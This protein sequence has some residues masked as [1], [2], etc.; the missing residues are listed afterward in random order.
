MQTITSQ[1]S[2][3][4][5]FALFTLVIAFIFLPL[6]LKGE[7]ICPFNYNMELGVSAD[8]N[9]SSYITNHKFGDYSHFFIPETSQN[10]Q[11]NS[12]S[13]ISVWSPWGE[14][15]RPTFTCQGVFGKAYLLTNMLSYFTSNP[16]V[17]QTYYAILMIF[18]SGAFFFLFLREKGLHPVS[19]STMAI[20]F[21]TSIFLFYWISFNIYLSTYCWTA[22]LL[23]LVTRYTKRLSFWTWFGVA[24]ATYSLLMTG[25]QQAIIMAAYLLVLYS[26]FH[27]WRLPIAC[28]G[29]LFRIAMLGL[30]AVAGFIAALPLY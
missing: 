22:A 5:T 12:R 15:G 24:F 9:E 29:K 13:W 10:L 8:A 27:V 1:L 2:Y 23:W 18:L 30:A 11:S 3:K 19:C 16:F 26:V 21:S 14:F 7:V 20:G 25:Y 17:F 28:G 4:S 6:L